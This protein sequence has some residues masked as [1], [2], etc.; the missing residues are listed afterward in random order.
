MAPE[1]VEVAAR[2]RRKSGSAASATS[3]PPSRA[4]PAADSS[5]APPRGARG[6]D[7]A[8]RRDYLLGLSLI[9]I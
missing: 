7:T 4:K 9:H 2:L 6:P 3:R 8:P 1:L 5:H